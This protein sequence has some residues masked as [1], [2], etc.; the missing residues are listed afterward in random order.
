MASSYLRLAAEQA[1]NAEGGENTVS[2]VTFDVPVTSLKLDP[3]PTMLDISDELRGYSAQAPH[4]GVA[5]Y[6]PSATFKTRTY[7]GV[8]G[9]LLLGACGS[10]TTTQGDG[11][12]VKD[13]DDAAIPATAYRHVYAWATGS[14]PQT[15]Q[16]QAAP[17]VGLF[18]KATGMGIDSLNFAVEDGCW[19]ADV[20]TKQLYTGIISDPSVTPSFET[21]DPF[22]AGTMTLTWLSNSATTKDFTFGISNQL[23]LER[24]FTTASLFPDSIT[25]D[26]PYQVVS[27][28][29]GKV[30]MDA[31]D[32]TALL[33]GTT[34]S[35]TIKMVHTE[36]I[37]S[38][39]YHH[40][41]WIEMPACQL[42]SGDI[43][44]ITND[45]RH[46]ATYEW[47]ARYDTSTSKW[48]TVTLVNAT[49]ALTAYA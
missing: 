26:T 24:Q 36:H 14:T 3:N 43:G 17:P 49:A 30:A 19:V 4:K 39:S 13:P 5:S 45:R 15:F 38:T 6:E 29:I 42:Q 28:T 12:A 23:I 46:E 35:A 1:P 21:P 22:V 34:F 7:P 27:G 8:L 41:L 32:W 11:S 31:D 48:A 44:E 2:S 37:A 10:V 33:A 18:Y 16:A 47:A 40:T 25:I 20:A 9:A